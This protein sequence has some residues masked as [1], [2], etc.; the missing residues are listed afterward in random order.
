M[1]GTDTRKRRPG[2]P[3]HGPTCKLCRHPEIMGT[4][5]IP[6]PGGKGGMGKTTSAVAIAYQVDAQYPSPHHASGT[7]SSNPIIA[8]GTQE[9]Y[10][11]VA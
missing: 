10:P 11:L 9:S 1:A 7:P 2:G 8:P 5:R 4:P 3:R 6:F